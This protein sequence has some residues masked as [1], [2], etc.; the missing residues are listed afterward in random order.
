MNILIYFKIVS[1]RVLACDID[2]VL[3]EGSEY[4]TSVKADVMGVESEV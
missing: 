4:H 1:Q 2:E 3:P